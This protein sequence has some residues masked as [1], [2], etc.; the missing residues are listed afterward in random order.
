MFLSFPD[1]LF[2]ALG[3]GDGNL[4]L[5]P[6]H[7]NHLTALGTVIVAVLA[8][9]QP[10]KKLEKFPV[11]LIPGIGIAGQGP[12]NG[13]DHQTVGNCGAEQIDQGTSEEGGDQA[14]R[15]TGAQ[16]RHIQPV[17]TVAANHE[18]LQLGGQLRHKLS[19]HCV[20]PVKEIVFYIILQNERISTEIL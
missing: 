12:A 15:K 7:P 10:V 4:A 1:K 18:A 9:F 17:G 2:P 3:A 14:C 20:S 13:P 8:I 5:A 6:G 11:F 19:E 16:D